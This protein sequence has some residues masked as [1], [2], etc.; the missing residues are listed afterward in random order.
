LNG[1][2]D[3]LKRE[4]RDVISLATHSAPNADSKF[5]PFFAKTANA[6]RQ[7]KCLQTLAA[8]ASMNH[9]AV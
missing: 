9:C 1:I 6:S 7:K 3:T 5:S 8:W 4:A 2:C